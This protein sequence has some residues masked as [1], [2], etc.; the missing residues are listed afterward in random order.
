MGK[1]VWNCT[2][3]FY[4][5]YRKDYWVFLKTK[6]NNINNE[7]KNQAK[8]KKT[9]KHKQTAAGIGSSNSNPGYT[10]REQTQYVEESYAL[11]C[12]FEHCAWQTRKGSSL[13]VHQLNRQVDK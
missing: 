11:L 3:E 8:P 1:D 12:S 5:H 2:L 13:S 4:S 10:Q 7:K 9:D 6:Q